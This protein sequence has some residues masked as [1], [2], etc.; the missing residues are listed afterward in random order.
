MAPLTRENS[1]IWLRVIP[2]RSPS[3]R[4]KD[5][6]EL[7]RRIAQRRGETDPQVRAD[8]LIQ[9]RHERALA[10][11]AHKL[12]ILRPPITYLRKSAAHDSCEVSYFENRGGLPAASKE[13]KTFYQ[14]K[15][16]SFLP[17]PTPSSIEQMLATHM[18]VQPAPFRAEFGAE[19]DASRRPVQAWMACA[20][21][22]YVPIIGKTQRAGSCRN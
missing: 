2:E 12:Q 14:N 18:S 15:Y 1:R 10:K 5:P 17:L 21:R 6:P 13:L 16:V 7:R 19:C 4:Y 20:M 11:T 8:L 3:L 9:L 22:P